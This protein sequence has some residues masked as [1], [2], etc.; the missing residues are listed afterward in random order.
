M[1]HKIA[2]ISASW[3]T[4][5]VDSAEHAFIQAMQEKGYAR[6]QIDIIKVPGSLEIPL[7]G[8]QCLQEGYDLAVGIGFV[9]NGL[10]YRH[11]FVGQEVVRG[12][13]EVS[14]KTGK[15]FLSVVLT[16]QAFQE[17]SPENI[18]FFA[19]HMVTKGREAAGAADMMLSM[20]GARLKKA[21]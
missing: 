3:H 7:V 8:Q 11:E 14:L 18:R 10:I 21:A 12:I 15:P 1:T 16:P 13:V 9:V 19:D 6:S 2:V 5:I 4:D 20:Q 17:H